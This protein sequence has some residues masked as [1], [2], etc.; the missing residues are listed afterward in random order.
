MSRPSSPAE[1]GTEVTRLQVQA[2]NFCEMEKVCSVHIWKEKKE[3]AALQGRLRQNHQRFPVGPSVNPLNRPSSSFH[4][5][6]CLLPEPACFF[7]FMTTAQGRAGYNSFIKSVGEDECVNGCV[8]ISQS[9]RPVGVSRGPLPR[10]H[11]RPS[12]K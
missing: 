7:L 6:M 1:G 5:F 2:R 4:E 10:G 8:C 11:C 12:H 9:D 3:G